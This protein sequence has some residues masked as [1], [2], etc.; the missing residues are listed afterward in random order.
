MSHCLIRLHPEASPSRVCPSM[1]LS[2]QRL[3]SRRLRSHPESWAGL[4][5]ARCCS[6][7]ERPVNTN[8]SGS[9][10]L[11]GRDSRG[12]EARQISQTPF[13]RSSGGNGRAV[14]APP[15]SSGSALVTTS[16]STVTD[17]RY[18][19]A[20]ETAATTALA[21]LVSDE[22][23]K[24]FGD[25]LGNPPRR[26]SFAGHQLAHAR[27]RENPRTFSEKNQN[28]DNFASLFP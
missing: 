22:T 20:A 12:D 4:D 13:L 6:R 21:F 9:G 3:H 24:A 2:S 17:R 25:D 26:A 16:I 14:L 18:R 10:R 1:S 7:N 19:I 23:P 8:S 15:R 5:I 27:R 11:D 28:F